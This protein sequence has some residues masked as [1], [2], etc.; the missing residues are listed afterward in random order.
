MRPCSI[1]TVREGAAINLELVEGS[2]S[3]QKLAAKYRVSKSALARHKNRCLAGKIAAA[4]QRAIEKNGQESDVLLAHL[5]ALID[6]VGNVLDRCERDGSY[7]LFFQGVREV[8]ELHKLMSQL[9]GR[10]TS[11]PQVNIFA[12][13][14]FQRVI[15]TI[16]KSLDAFPDAKNHLVNV[17]SG[18][19]RLPILPTP[20]AAFDD[21]MLIDEPGELEANQD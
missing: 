9:E 14:D 15:A 3:L 1:C 2:L 19:L 21:A 17:L 12:S 5:K 10:L 20:A 4:Q 6:R 8:R 11:G 18:K 16:V 13:V 7:A